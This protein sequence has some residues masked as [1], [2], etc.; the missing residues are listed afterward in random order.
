MNGKL[1]LFGSLIV[2][3]SACFTQVNTNNGASTENTP[4]RIFCYINPITR[5]TSI[6]MR[7]HCIIKAGNQWCC[8]G[9]SNPVWTG[10]NPD[11]IK[12]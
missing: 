1:I 9:T 5:D 4:R 8:T 3:S 11:I 10:P 7:D 6:S 12:L 2:L